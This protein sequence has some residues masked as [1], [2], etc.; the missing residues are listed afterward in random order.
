M[1]AR[2]LTGNESSVMSIGLTTDSRVAL[3]LCFCRTSLEHS[4]F[5]RYYARSRSANNDIIMDIIPQLS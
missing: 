4:A 3:V 2:I 1:I 5:R